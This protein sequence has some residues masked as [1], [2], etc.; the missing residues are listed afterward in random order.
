MSIYAQYD[1]STNSSNTNSISILKDDF[2]IIEQYT[3]NYGADRPQ[4][5]LMCETLR[6]KGKLIYNPI[7]GYAGHTS[8][9][10]PNID[11]NN[12]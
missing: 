8:M 6:K 9:L 7:P 4:D 1:S 10:S 2:S 3:K 12:V 5:Y 11:W